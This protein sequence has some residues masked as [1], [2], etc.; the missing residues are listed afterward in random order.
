MAE[1]ELHLRIVRACEHE[2]HLLRRLLTCSLPTLPLSILLPRYVQPQWV[3]DCVNAQLLLP[4]AWYA[5]G[6]ELPP[7]LSPFVDN[8]EVGYTPT[9]AKRIEAVRKGVDPADMRGA[10]EDGNAAAADGEEEEVEGAEAMYVRELEAEQAK[11][12]GAGAGAAGKKK[13]RKRKTKK[14]QADAAVAADRAEMAESMMPR[15]IKRLHGRIVMSEKNKGKKA[16]QLE[17]KRRKLER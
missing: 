16:K 10:L 5:H 3:Y 8:A 1:S 6:A 13:K 11:A 14:Q 15:K 7:H 9:F 12:S 4:C 17:K 2:N